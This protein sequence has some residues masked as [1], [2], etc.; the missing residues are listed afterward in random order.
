MAIRNILNITTPNFDSRLEDI[1]QLINFSTQYQSLEAFL[2][3]L[4]LLSGVSGEEIVSAA[5]DDEK[6]ILST[7]HQAKGL[8]WK[9]VFLIWCAEGRFPNPKAIEEG[10][11]EEERRLFV[12]LLHGLWTNCIC[13]IPF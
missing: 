6:M 12:W 9:A 13:V 8:E 10:N 4:S 5:M 7:I 2:S 11:D 3:E 1:G